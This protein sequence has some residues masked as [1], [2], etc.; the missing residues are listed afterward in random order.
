MRCYCIYNEQEI[1]IM[2][3]NNVNALNKELVDAKIDLKKFI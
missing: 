2:E 1:T 3:Q